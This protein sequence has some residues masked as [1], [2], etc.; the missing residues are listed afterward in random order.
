MTGALQGSEPLPLSFR[1]NQ[2]LQSLLKLIVILLRLE[3]L[4]KLSQD[5]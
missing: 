1:L 5:E 4:G 3:R 2:F